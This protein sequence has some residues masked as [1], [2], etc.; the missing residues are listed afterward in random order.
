MKTV[1]IING[2]CRAGGNTDHLLESLETGMADGGLGIR[3]H[4]LR[5]E[6][7]DDCRGCYYCYKNQSCALRDD[8]QTIHSDIQES[9]MMILASP[10]YWWGYTGLMKTFIDRLYLYYPRKNGHLIRG[11]K[12]VILMPMHVNEKEHGL[13]AYES[14]IEPLTMAS[15]YIFKR[16][17]VDIAGIKFF[18]GLNDK[19]AL[20]AH[21]EYLT[22]SCQLG[23]NIAN[24]VNNKGKVFS[25][26]GKRKRGDGA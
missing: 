18:P 13:K 3:K 1:T 10:M 2:S 12:A 9:E 21:S 15:N 17:G 6:R 22:L 19:S 23:K 20:K 4:V 5:N 25:G 14:E 7:I 26:L 11:K 16:L 8:M 24:F